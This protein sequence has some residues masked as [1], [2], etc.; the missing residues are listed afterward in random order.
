M[1]KA[2]PNPAPDVIM[3]VGSKFYP[4]SDSY[5]TEAMNLGCS[6]RLPKGLP[7]DIVP[8]KSRCFL[9]HDEGIKGQGA[10]F[11]FFVISGVEVILDDE[12]KIAQYQEEHAQLN[13]KPVSRREALAEPRRLC[14]HRVYGAS[15]LVSEDD[16]DKVWEAAEPL[17]DKCDIRGGLV[18]LLHRITY[19]RLRFR[20]WRYMEPEFLSGYD[21]PQRSLPVERTVKIEH[22]DPQQKKPRNP[23][24]T[25]LF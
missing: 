7:S 10:I 19:P 12:E 17:A 23:D 21:W 8:G 24:Q 22:R 16:M 9:A 11:G 15:Y 6:K 4:T 13:V 25:T 5:I 2:S 14:G 1:G 18:V 20:G 3:W